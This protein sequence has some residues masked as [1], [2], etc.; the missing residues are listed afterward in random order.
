MSLGKL[1]SCD[2]LLANK[3][4][5]VF[6]YSEEV[7]RLLS[8]QPMDEDTEE[9]DESLLFVSSSVNGALPS[10]ST[11]QAIP[12]PSPPP[13][14]SSPH[15]AT[16]MPAMPTEPPRPLEPRTHDIPLTLGG[17]TVEA[18]PISANEAPPEYTLHAPCPE[19][20]KK[21]IKKTGMLVDIQIDGK[22]VPGTVMEDVRKL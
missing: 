12:P 10:S 2:L 6:F 16:P 18:A 13:S 20:E 15:S 14:Y 4:D 1:R 22:L 7:R 5:V 8:N 3:P 11:G 9:E 21:T 17:A 19:G